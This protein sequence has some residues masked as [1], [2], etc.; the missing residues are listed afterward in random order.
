MEPQNTHVPYMKDYGK[1]WSPV[2]RPGRFRDVKRLCSPGFTKCTTSCGCGTGQAES[3]PTLPGKPSAG[4]EIAVLD[5]DED[6]E[7]LLTEQVMKVQ[8]AMDSGAIAHVTP[9]DCVPRDCPLD[10]SRRRNFTA[11][12]GGSIKNYG[13]ARVELVDDKQGQAECVYNVA[14]VTR[15]LHSTGQVCDQDF[16]CLYM[17]QGCVV[18]PEGTLSRFLE[19]K[20]IVTRYP[21]RDGGLYVAEFTVRAPQLKQNDGGTP[22]DFTRRGVNP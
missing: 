17:K 4:N 9:P 13:Q 20:D 7:V 19:D 15:T 10:E 2:K 21:R 8:V 18:V 6:E 11:A 12:N 3:L 5:Y 1:G 14:E 22:A 16:E